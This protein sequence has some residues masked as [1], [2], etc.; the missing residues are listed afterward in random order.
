MRK[1]ICLAYLPQHDIEDGWLVMM[2]NSLPAEPVIKFNDYFVDQWLEP[3]GMIA[4]WCCYK[5][6]HRSTYLVEAWNCYYY[7]C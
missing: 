2:V 7:Y 1:C 3:D 5:E 6:Q 4:K